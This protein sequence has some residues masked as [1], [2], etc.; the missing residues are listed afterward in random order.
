MKGR[1]G[2]R[3]LL[4]GLALLA[5]AMLPAL[6]PL[7]G[8]E[9][10]C[11]YDNIFHLWRAAQVDHLWSQG[12]LYS[13]WA[14]DMAHGF[15][16]PLFVFASPFPPA[17][18]AL[19]HRI[20]LP[21]PNALNAVFALGVVTG[22]YAMFWLAYC[23]IRDERRSR[24][25]ALAAGFIAGVAYVYAPF[26]AYDIFN[27]GSLWESFAWAFPPLVL[28]GVHRWSLN[29]DRRYLL[30][31]AMAL[32]AMILSHHVFA[33]LFGPLFG[34][35]VV[36]H[37]LHRRDGSV[38]GRGV[39]LGLL[40]LG[41][42]AFFWLPPLLEK[43][44]VQS[45]RLLNIWVFEYQHNFLLLRHLLALP[46]RA[47]PQLLNDWPEKAL[48]LVPVLLA[49]LPAIGWRRFSQ[50]HRLRLALLWFLTVLF[51]LLTLPAS[52]RLWDR[53]PL[54]VY[55]QFPWRFLGPAAFCVALL[56]GWGAAALWDLFPRAG[57]TAS[58][59]RSELR[60]GWGA[61]LLTAGVLSLVLTANLGWFYPHHCAAL[62][63][64]S[65]AAM[66]GWERITDTLGSTAKG[67]YLPQW[68]RRFPEE[69]L[70]DDYAAGGPIVRLR[71]ES[72][73]EGARIEAAEYGATRARI[74]LS[75]PVD[76]RARYLAFYYPGWQVSVDGQAVDVVPD[77]ETG[78]VTFAVPA[79]E[80]TVEIRFGETPARLAADAVSVL[81]LLGWAGMLV[82]GADA[83]IKGRRARRIRPQ[84]AT[85]AGD[86]RLLVAL[87]V[88]LVGVL[89]VKWLVVD[90]H[91][92]GWRGS[93]L[94][95]ARTLTGLDPAALDRLPAPVNFG[96]Q[97]LLL[98]MEPLPE[99]AAADS[100]TVLTLYWRAL[101]P[102][103]RD[104]RV[105]LALV[106]EDAPGS[107]NAGR[108]TVEL[109]PAR[110]AR[111]APPLT[112]WSPDAYARMDLLMDLPPGMPPGR[113]EVQLALFDRATAEPASVLN[114][115]GNPVGPAL[116]LGSIEVA[117][118]RVQPALASLG[119]PAEPATVPASCGAIGLWHAAPDRS[120][121]AP[122]EGVVV[123]TVWE[124]VASPDEASRVRLTLLDDT[125]AVREQ[126]ERPPVAASWPTTAWSAGERWVGRA[127]IRLPGSL[128]T[129]SYTLALDLDTCALSTWP[130]A[131]TAPERSWELGA[132]FAPVADASGP[133][134][135]VLGD[136][137]VRLAGV[138]GLVGE[139]GAAR[140][141]QAGERIELALAWE[142][143]AEM[144]VA[145]RVFVH[146]LDA[147]GN[148][149]D[150]SD[151]EPAGWTRPTTGWAVGEIVA[152]ARPLTL[153]ASTGPGTYLIRAGLYG[154]DGVRL[155]TPSGEDG[156]RIGEIT[157]AP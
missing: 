114:A 81:S 49:L 92:V 39:L 102:A 29:R 91:G 19:L 50:A 32:G 99:R 140:A 55:V 52:R 117:P 88:A 2:R 157:V 97:A 98:G 54:L 127:E 101:A 71:P 70:D 21:W 156:I 87:A 17:L 104:W 9:L 115:E 77:A 134:A 23:L 25:A 61:G 40:G 3:P 7:L 144:Q 8:S 154:P 130:V 48:G 83:P 131:V 116:S 67:E 10:T 123:R 34:L 46:R 56:T 93:R 66:I 41:L 133:D 78:L 121:A 153:P 38:L 120:A 47:D 43:S 90:A 147:E 132:G 113:Y 20:G 143:L 4:F 145:Y 151:G 31:G 152:E 146:L 96:N 85:G 80:R 1:P 44:L 139:D 89:G 149:L 108:W 82:V 100:E 135:L 94:A 64:T 69:T 95:E 155:T 24:T 118:P 148:L 35:W 73:P 84:Q 62:T 36:V 72:L 125:G 122:G 137:V 37:A 18:V 107:G 33:F 76:F 142:A 128:E 119:V 111:S 86:V 5:V 79:G 28:L 63:D 51:A 12:V 27:R 68:V 124:A 57:G 14:P 11:G 141:W 42:T 65:M 53:V 105:G 6:Q 74:S 110:W 103:P 129:G 150:Q 15:G 22:G 109:R 59:A 75:S 30:L 16:F 45:D 106:A 138:R 60:S 26:Q 136:G 13:R 112:E 58:E 126:W